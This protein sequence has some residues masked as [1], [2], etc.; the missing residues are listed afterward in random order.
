MLERF[1]EKTMKAYLLGTGFLTATAFM[2][3]L[4][5]EWSMQNLFFYNEAMMENKE[6]LQAT[7]QHWGVMVGCIGVLL[8]FSAKY[9]QL[10]TSTMIYSAFEKSMFVG[11][12]LYNVC[13]NE[14]SWFYGWSG[15]FAL[16]GF[17]TVYSLVYLY[18]YLTR[19]KSKT[20]AHLR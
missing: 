8:M 13:V 11:L 20:P 12:F 6:Y 9:K 17:V 14:Y 2:T 16:D 10:R 1:F 18:Y 7:Y 5:P 19:D 15:V 4:A 3:F